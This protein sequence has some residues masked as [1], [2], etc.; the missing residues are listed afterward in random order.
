[1]PAAPMQASGPIATPYQST[2]AVAIMPGVM[3]MEPHVDTLRAAPL[4]TALAPPA[5]AGAAMTAG[6]PPGTSAP[7]RRGVSVPALVGLSLLLGMSVVGIL[8]GTGTLALSSSPP[9]PP[10]MPVTPPATTT[11]ASPATTPALP[12]ATPTTTAVPTLTP[13]HPTATPTTPRPSPTPKPAPGAADA[14]APPP[15]FP[16]PTTLP[17]FPSGFPFPTALPSGFPTALPSGFPT[18]PGWPPLPTPLP[19]PKPSASASGT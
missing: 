16:F 9:E 15:P 1:M 2:E 5:Y 12:T 11:A 10:Q 13:P 7:S 14:A 18:I 3:D 17:P 6:V 8:V 4:A 19:P